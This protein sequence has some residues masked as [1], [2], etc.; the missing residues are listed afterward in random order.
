MRRNVKSIALRAP[1]VGFDGERIFF[2][3]RRYTQLRENFHQFLLRTIDQT[4]AAGE[5]VP[6]LFARRRSARKRNT[7]P[8]SPQSMIAWSFRALIPAFIFTTSS[9]S[10]TP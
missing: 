10:E 1:S 4:R 3:F 2:E 5:F 8:P 7:V 9:L 6:A